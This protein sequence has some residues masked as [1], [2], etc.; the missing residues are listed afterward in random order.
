MRNNNT[1]TDFKSES[2]N[3]SATLITDVIINEYLCFSGIIYYDSLLEIMIF[4]QI[5]S[6]EIIISKNESVCVYYY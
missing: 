6:V 4:L 1:H 5:Q 3:F 2:M